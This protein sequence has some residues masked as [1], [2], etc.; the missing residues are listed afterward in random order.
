MTVFMYRVEHKRTKEGPYNS[1]HCP[2]IF[3]K[4]NFNGRKWPMPSN[5]FYNHRLCSRMVFGF[6]NHQ[7][8]KKWFDEDARTYMHN[9]GMVVGMYKV[10][11]YVYLNKQMAAIVPDRRSKIINLTEI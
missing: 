3:N 2:L 7:Q 11:E 6:K 10:T 5:R 9:M 4:Y 8:L 1:P